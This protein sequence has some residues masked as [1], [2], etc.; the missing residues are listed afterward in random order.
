MR[1]FIPAAAFLILSPETAL[2]HSS[3]E[4][5]G[6]FPN[7]L[8]HPVLE[9]VHAVCLLAGSLLIAH[10]P[11]ERMPRH[12]LSVVL[13]LAAGLILS[14]FGV[15]ATSS[16]WTAPALWVGALLLGL[17]VAATQDRD[18]AYSIGLLAPVFL[19]IGLD[20]GLDAA[21]PVDRAVFA[22]G[23]WL[24]VSLIVVNAALALRKI[25]R[26]AITRIG[27]RVLASWVAAASAMML[28][29]SLRGGS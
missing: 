21:R 14:V 19:A 13:P 18:Y 7:G 4:G 22:A 24:G 16:T 27:M 8:L 5:I 12:F 2:A 23:A 20:T 1:A 17:A 11:E 28:A 25:E 6:S 26:L 10:Q 3:L 15:G 9:P 29:F